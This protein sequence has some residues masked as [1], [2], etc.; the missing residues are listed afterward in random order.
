MS[1]SLWEAKPM[2]KK[3]FPRNEGSHMRNMIEEM[4]VLACMGW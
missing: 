3:G 1:F 4:S 2:Q